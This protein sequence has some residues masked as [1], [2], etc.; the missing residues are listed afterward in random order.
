MSDIADNET[1]EVKGSAVK[2]Y[3]LKNVGGVYSC[4]CPAWRNQSAPIEQ[5]T[6]KH[7]R[8]YRGEQAEK[9]RL[10]GILPTKTIKKS[11]IKKDTPPLLL[12]T[13]WDGQQDITGWWMSE[14][15]DGVR[16]YWTGEK[17]LSRQGN[18]YHAPDWFVDK[19]PAFPLDGELW[20]DRKMFQK[21]VSIVRRQDKSE[22]WKNIRFLVFDAPAEK[23]SFEERLEIIRTHLNSKNTYI[24]QLS[25]IPCESSVHLKEEL[26]RVEALGGE[27]LMLRQPKSLYEIGRSNTLLKIKSFIDAEAV[28][29]EYQPGKGKHKGKMGA[30]SVQ[31]DNGTLF[32]IG[33][34]FS[35]HQR[36]NPPEIGSTISFRYQELSDDGVPRFPSFLRIREDIKINISKQKSPP[37]EQ[38]MK[39]ENTNN[40]AN[41]RRFEF[42]DEK[43]NKFWEISLDNTNVTVRYGRLGTNGTSKTKTFDT[44]ELATKHYDKLIS[45]KTAKGY[46]ETV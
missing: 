11:N 37:E 20:M 3:L 40:Q 27:G 14:K 2:P 10:G 12:A 31:L 9:D 15:L 30:L 5:R 24:E 16:A 1:V 43:S 26:Q 28:V 36:A 17:F 46:T 6:C 45:Q 25:H 4:S 32:S 18:E 41:L 39:I 33:T 22:H 21:T 29:L 8:Q 13:A 23:G 38:N 34:G 35:D 44:K 42:S 19:L 7:L